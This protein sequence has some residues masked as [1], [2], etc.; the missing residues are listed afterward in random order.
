VQSVER[1]QAVL[2]LVASRVDRDQ[3]RF[4]VARR[5]CASGIDPDD[6]AAEGLDDHFPN[7]PRATVVLH[8]TSWRYADGVLT[9]TYLAYS[10]ELP[11]SALPLALPPTARAN[12]DS[13]ESVVAHAIRHLAFLVAEEPEKYARPL[14]AETIAYLERIEPDVAGR[15]H[16][17]R[18]A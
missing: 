8:S 15:I 10:D 16:R 12:G 7:V 5:A 3:V 9:L 14:S 17:E 2:E 1:M 18:V 13:A 11:L 6:I 4:M